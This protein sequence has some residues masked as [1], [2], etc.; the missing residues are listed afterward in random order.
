MSEELKPTYQ[1]DEI[2]LFELIETLWKEKVLIILFT[3]VAAMGGTG[4]AFL[5]TPK[6]S[7]SVNY[8]V[9]SQMPAN[10]AN[11]VANR[12]F[13]QL[14]AGW[15]KEKKSN[16]AVLTTL[17][18]ESVT[19]Y[20]NL[21]SQLERS[22]SKEFLSEA[23]SNVGIIINDLPETLQSTEAVA[24]Q[25]LQSKQTIRALS[26]GGESIAFSAPIISQTAPKKALILG[27]SVVLGGMVGV[28]FV[29]IRSAVRNRKAKA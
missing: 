25:M 10:D 29:L 26:D 3:V 9:N 15:G 4:Y 27:L 23:E 24:L 7:V 21:F 13:A 20:A 5:A 18:P 16:T 2:D 19:Q 17:A 14:P 6:Y 12:L 22:I 8:T 11:D 1:N 28:M